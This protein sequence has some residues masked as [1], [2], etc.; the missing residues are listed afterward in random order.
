MNLQSRNKINAEFSMASMTDLVFLMLIFFMI[1]S[2]L[3][4]TNAIEIKLPKASGQTLKKQIVS[5][6]VT[7]DGVYYIDREQVNFNDIEPRL[8]Q[9]AEQS[10]K[11]TILIRGEKTVELQKVTDLFELARRNGFTPIL[12]VQPTGK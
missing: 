1:S 11:P 8:R 3:I 10:E 7:Q 4:N 5:L 9:L 2:T 6:S 12:G